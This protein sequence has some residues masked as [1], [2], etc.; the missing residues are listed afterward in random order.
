MSGTSVNS[1]Y[2]AAAGYGLLGMIIANSNTVHQQLNTLTAQAS[3]GRIADSY[4]GLGSGATTSLVLNAAVADQNTWSSNIN[5]AGGSMQVAQTALSQISSIA[6]SFYAQTNN[7]NG[8]NPSTVD[9]VAADARAALRQVAGLLDSTNGDT[10]VFAGQDSRNPPVP[11]P[12]NINN[13]G[14]ATQVSAAVGNLAVAGPAATIAATLGIAGSNAAGT[15]PFS[16]ALS[17]PAAALA[18][19]LPTIQVGASQQAQVGILASANA[20]VASTGASTTG[21]YTRD[22]MRALATLGSLSSGMVNTAGFGQLVADTQTSLG[23]A[24]TALNSDAGVMGDRQ[25]QL[26][27]QQSEL[28]HTTTALQGQLSTAQDVDMATTLS[29]LQQV[30][31]QLQASYQLIASVASLSLTKYLPAG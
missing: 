26:T 14:F 23:N 3:S 18:G 5:A 12:D 15:S 6:S 17:Q 8:L 1:V 11:D 19:F 9:V 13:S 31:T 22:I 28:A 21:S 7:L 25:T 29:R 10:Y 30:E 27:A 20:D 4:A 2:G 16:A 24:I